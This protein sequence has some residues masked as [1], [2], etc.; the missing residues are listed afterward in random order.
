MSHSSPIRPLT[1]HH[2]KTAAGLHQ[3]G[4]DTGFL[5][6]LGRRFLI[7]L[8]KAIPSCP[9]GFGYVWEQS[10]GTILG[11][12]TCAE[13]T[14]LVY[15]QALLRRG[16][17]M[18]IP[19]ARFL[20]RPSVIRRMVQTLRYPTKVGSELPTAEILSIVVS[21]NARGKGIGKKLMESALEEF[22]HRGIWRVKLAVGANNELANAFYKGC[23]FE[24]AL[25]LEHH[26]LPMNLY[27]IDLKT[28]D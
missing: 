13:S 2:A 14:G 5:S 21:A 4:I 26:G 9:A 19:L 22:Q 20:F 18:A 10:D 3:A 28:L 16:L 23:N 12:I 6:S 7:Q 8:Y 17:L 15:K 11:F 27:K 24:L 25:T 1:K